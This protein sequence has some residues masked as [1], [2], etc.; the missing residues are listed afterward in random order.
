MSN[1][2]KL[3]WIIVFLLSLNIVNAKAL[4]TSQINDLNR[5]CVLK[6]FLDI[7]LTID[8]S[9]NKNYAST[10]QSVQYS[11]DEADCVVGG[12]GFSEGVDLARI[13]HSNI[14][15]YNSMPN[16][17]ACAW[18]NESTSAGSSYVRNLD[19]AVD[20][21]AIFIELT[22]GGFDAV[23]YN[24]GGSAVP[25]VTLAHDGTWKM[26]CFRAND[27][28]VCQSVNASINNCVASVTPRTNS[29]DV[30]IFAR[31]QAPAQDAITGMDEVLL[32]NKTFTM[33]ELNYTWWTNWYDKKHLMGVAVAEVADTTPPE[34]T[35]LNLTS[36]GGVGQEVNHTDPFCRT[37]ANCVIPR[38][39]DTTPTFRVTLNENGNITIIDLNRN[40]NYTDIF[41]GNTYNVS[42][43]T[44]A[45]YAVV[46]LNDSNVTRIGLWNF[47]IG[48]TDTTG[49]QNRSGCLFF[50]INITDPTPPNV[51]IFA[52][53]NKSV[54]KAG[55]NFTLSSTV[56]NFNW[57]ARDNYDSSIAN[58]SLY[59]NDVYLFNKTNYANGTKFITNLT[60]DSAGNN[61][62]WY[63]NCTDSFGN[64]N[65]SPFFVFSILEQTFTPNITIRLNGTHANKSYEFNVTLLNTDY[66]VAINITIDPNQ[67]A[68]LDFDYFIN[69]TRLD[70]NTTLY[71]NITELNQT[72][73]NNTQI[74]NLTEGIQNVSIKQDNN[75]DLLRVAFKLKGYAVNN[76]FP[77]N[78]TIDINRDNKSDF[79]FP[80]VIRENELEQTEFITSLG[81]RNAQN[82]TFTS[83]GSS[84]IN[85]NSTTALAYKN[86]SVSL[87]G[88]GLDLRNG[89]SYIEHFNGTT[90]KGFNETLTVQA[91]A[92]LG[93]FDDFTINRSIWTATKSVAGTSIFSYTQVSGRLM[94]VIEGA[95]GELTIDYSDA[96]ADFRNSSRV[97]ILAT[98]QDANP[99][100][101]HVRFRMTDGTNNIN[102]HTESQAVEPTYYNYTFLK[103]STDYKTWELLRNGSSVS[104]TDLSS[105]DYDKQIKF[106]I[107][108][109]SGVTEDGIIE[110]DKV[111]WSG[112]WLNYS[113]NNGTYKPTGNFTSVVLNYTNTNVSRATLTWTA[114]EPTG[115]K[116]V[117]YISNVCNSSNPIFQSVTSGVNTIF[118][119]DGNAPCVRFNLNSSVNTSSPVVRKYTF[120]ITKG[121]AKNIT[122]DCGADGDSDW[123]YPFELNSTTSPRIANCSVSEFTTY[124]SDS[125]SGTLCSLPVSFSLQSAGIISINSVNLTQRIEDAPNLTLSADIIISNLTK[126]EHLNN[127][128]WTFKFVN[129]ILE[130]SNLDI[131]FLGSK[132][133]T[134]FAH[135]VENSSYLL[136]TDNVTIRVYY[137]KFNTSFPSRVF[138]YNVFAFSSNASNLSPE[139]QNNLTPIWNITNLAYE[140]DLD[141]Y[142]RF[143][144]TLNKCLNS[145]FSN[146]SNK[147]D[148]IEVNTSFK[149]ILSNISTIG[150]LNFTVT[151][152]TINMT[153]NSTITNSTLLNRSSIRFNQTT[154]VNYSGTPTLIRDREY[155]IDWDKGNFTLLNSTYNQ[156]RLYITYNY[157]REKVSWKG[158]WNYWDLRNCTGRYIIP[159]FVFRSYCTDCIR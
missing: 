53:S 102:I 105:L 66:G 24:G 32:C 145:T 75:T 147:A 20:G 25:S 88:G 1:L 6:N 87:S 7:N 60:Y 58:C 30:W 45:G 154:V 136:G 22:A 138:Y 104:T 111:S 107:F 49:N 91:D 76:L 93:I 127:W 101:N 144:G 41:R 84:T 63:V 44:G 26:V 157:T 79:I 70:G 12:C 141:L 13:I 54:F 18:M 9:T 43:T 126:L 114:Y 80:G 81:K 36:E 85:V 2:N 96:I 92:P 17:T 134:L 112:G 34:V 72:F 56:L 15:A 50:S 14:G 16:Y 3:I 115:T 68:Y 128:N 65:Q 57:T 78:V 77:T 74:V 125:C 129:G 83:A 86:F 124:R 108:L 38:T 121:T 33:E 156:S 100:G 118:T 122:M 48:C 95:S 143:N 117:G 123:N 11:S 132:N 152:E 90:A 151:N 5:S 98:V 148:G 135:S 8:N 59:I 31:E 37:L 64:K 159:E 71:I 82:I 139:G 39:N 67:T 51:T 21:D 155:K 110:F 150:K 140:K 142:V 158:I 46:T 28:D 137:S 35:D 69:W 106:Q 94:A 4:N 62:V 119:Q 153:I 130:L 109:A 120:D 103:R 19:S 47:S 23:L 99:S 113:T 27:T 89:F 97:E 52:I 73:F 116:V 133:I 10:N 55:T 40:L 149:L 146:N 61:I 42:F 29:R 131:E